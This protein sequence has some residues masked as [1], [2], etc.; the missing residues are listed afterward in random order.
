MKLIIAGSRDLIITPDEIKNYLVNHNVTLNQIEEV[1]SGQACGIDT[2]GEVFARNFSIKTKRFKVTPNDW[3][4]KG[5]GAGHIRNKKMA[6]YGDMLAVFW[7][8]K[9]GG[10][11]N[12]KETMEN[13]GKPVLEFIL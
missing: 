8:G 2:C 12:M 10:S 11:F 3:K 7:D 6:L 5:K 13:L 1:V 4:T 9:S